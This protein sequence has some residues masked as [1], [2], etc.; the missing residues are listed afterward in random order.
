M[1]SLS[2][3]PALRFPEWVFKRGIQNHAVI[4]RVRR[5][6]DRRCDS[7]DGL[8]VVRMIKGVAKPGRDQC[9]QVSLGSTGLI[10]L[11]IPLGERFEHEVE[12]SRDGVDRARAE[13]ITDEVVALYVRKPGRAG[14]RVQRA[15]IAHDLAQ[16]HVH[17]IPDTVVAKAIV[18]VARR[19]D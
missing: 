9:R 19:Q 2:T 13:I 14:I 15:A 18:H 16:R 12:I 4:G 8:R 5:E 11:L 17:L 6:A 7:D 10:H 1:P 3:L